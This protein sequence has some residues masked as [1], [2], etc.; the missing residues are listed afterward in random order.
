MIRTLA[1]TN[2]IDVWDAHHKPTSFGRVAVQEFPAQRRIGNFACGKLRLG[3]VVAYSGLLH[4]FANRRLSVAL[5][6]A[7]SG[8]SVLIEPGQR[9]VH[10]HISG[11]MPGRK[12]C[13]ERPV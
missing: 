8:E 9:E 11:W 5:M 10:L 2:G 13:G 6:N 1:R 3:V 12:L 4:R 7:S